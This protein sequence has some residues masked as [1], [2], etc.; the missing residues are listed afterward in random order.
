M[1]SCGTEI[2]LVSLVDDLRQEMDRDN[3][4]LL[5]LVDLLV[6][7]IA[8]HHLILLGCLSWF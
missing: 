2:L 1:S 8:I 4:S 6:A 3:A 5:M 7:F